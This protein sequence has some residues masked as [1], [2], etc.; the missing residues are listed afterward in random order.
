MLET[1]EELSLLLL[2]LGFV[3]AVS[4]VS[5]IYVLVALGCKW[6]LKAGRKVLRLPEREQEPDST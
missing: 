4:L 6:C 1:L 2:R 5:M 3:L